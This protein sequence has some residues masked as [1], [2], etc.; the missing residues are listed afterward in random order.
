MRTESETQAE[1]QMHRFHYDHSWENKKIECEIKQDTLVMCLENF[2]K[3]H[4]TKMLESLMFLEK[5]KHD[6]GREIRIKTLQWVLQTRHRE[7]EA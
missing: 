6:W 1:L 5:T 2:T 4:V 7:K 3:E